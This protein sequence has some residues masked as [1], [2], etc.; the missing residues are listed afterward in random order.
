MK[1]CNL[2]PMRI[3]TCVTT[4]TTF[5]IRKFALFACRFWLLFF[6]H[7]AHS[8]VTTGKCTVGGT[9]VEFGAYDNHIHNEEVYHDL[10]SMKKRNTLLSQVD[11]W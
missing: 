3:A 2:G 1:S 7:S 11:D 4:K 5:L 9:D 8:E 10:C 6:D